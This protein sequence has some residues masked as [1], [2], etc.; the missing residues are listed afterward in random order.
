[1]VAQ[2]SGGVHR[3]SE[4]SDITNAHPVPGPGVV[5]GLAQVGQ[6]LGRGLLLLAEMSSQGSLA[7]GEYT[8]GAVA[9]ALAAPAFVCG[10]ISVRPARW[11]GWPTPPGLIHM[12]PG[13]QL[14]AGGDALGQQYLTP[15]DVVQ[16]GTDVIIV[17]RGVTAAKDPAAAAAAYREAGWAAYEAAL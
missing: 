15:G 13:V 2:Y 11:P 10:F 4:W 8:A 16:E 12:T 6:P 5:A 9:M 17:G 7:V 3:I 14:A 1:M